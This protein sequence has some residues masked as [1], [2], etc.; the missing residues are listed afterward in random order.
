MIDFAKYLIDNGIDINV[1]NTHLNNGNTPLFYA[2]FSGNLLMVE[3]LIS[4]CANIN[5]RDFVVLSF[6]MDFPP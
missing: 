1:A 2:I 5:Q 3:F 4:N 6:Q